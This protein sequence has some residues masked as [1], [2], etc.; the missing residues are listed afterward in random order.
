MTKNEVSYGSPVSRRDWLT[1][2]E[3]ADALGVAQS[4]LR[5]WDNNGVFDRTWRTPGGH[6]R[7]SRSEV[8][9]LQRGRRGGEPAVKSDLVSLV[10]LAV[11]TVRSHGAGASGDQLRLLAGDLDQLAGTCRELADQMRREADAASR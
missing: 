7:F 4:T 5:E 2:A 3:A 1:L 8:E 6:R 11:E 9:A 10:E